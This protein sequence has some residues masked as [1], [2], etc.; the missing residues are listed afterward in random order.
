MPGPLGTPSQY[1]RIRHI[2]LMTKNPWFW[3]SLI[4]PPCPERG[5][6][7]SD[8]ELFLKNDPRSNP[9]NFAGFLLR[10]VQF[11]LPY[12]KRWSAS[13]WLNLGKIR[14][15]A[16]DVLD[17]IRGNLDGLTPTASSFR[18]WRL[19]NSDRAWFAAL[20]ERC[21]RSALSSVRSFDSGT[22]Q[23]NEAD[24]FC[25][26]KAISLEFML[27]SMR[28]HLD[29]ED[30]FRDLTISLS[31]NARAKNMH[32]IWKKE[33]DSWINYAKAESQISLGSLEI[34]RAR[35]SMLGEHAINEIIH[36][37]IAEDVMTGLKLANENYLRDFLSADPR[38]RHS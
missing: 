8:Q 9:K 3:G 21:R 15:I 13:Y 10:L 38:N 17:D 11:E 31:L 16:R 1:I 27:Q 7:L 20:A 12:D 24:L 26:V 22:D 37:L 30:A 29:K 4:E 5:W 35:K 34:A 25:M 32:S 2:E 14:K 36:R 6:S 19:R 18:F 28:T 33:A 23:Y